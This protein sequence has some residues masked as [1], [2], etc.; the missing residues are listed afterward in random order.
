MSKL[1]ECGGN[2][3]EI[4]LLILNDNTWS[5]SPELKQMINI[6]KS[7]FELAIFETI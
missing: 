3:L 7:Y 5:H 6:E 4:E 1:F 2:I